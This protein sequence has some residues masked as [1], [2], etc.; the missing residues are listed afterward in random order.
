MARGRNKKASQAEKLLIVLLSGREISLEELEGTL[1]KQI[2]M[3]RL[4]TYLYDL[5]KVG[6]KIGV[7]KCGRKMIAVQL[8]NV[9]EMQKYMNSRIEG[10]APLKPKVIPKDPDP[11]FLQ[12]KKA[13]HDENYLD[14][15]EE[16]PV[17]IFSADTEQSGN[18]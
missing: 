12:L 14:P 17:P 18:W 13:D 10:N 5:K 2:W 16:P 7:K 4:S 9:D 6:A 3:Y 1:G 15:D 11:S 8:L